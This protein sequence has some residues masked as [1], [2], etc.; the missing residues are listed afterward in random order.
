MQLE[1]FI[2]EDGKMESE[3]VME[4]SITKMVKNMWAVLLTISIMVKV[5]LH[6]LMANHTL[7]TISWVRGMAKEK[8]H[9]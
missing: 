1:M 7:V 5:S 4:N 9:G 8:F 6:G 3:M 2:K